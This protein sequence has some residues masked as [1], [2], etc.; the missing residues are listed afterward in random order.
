MVEATPIPTTPKTNK[1]GMTRND[2]IGSASTLCPGCGHD[3][4]TSS[5]ITACFELGVNPTQV[6]KMSG[7]GCSS[8]TPA[9]F[10]KTSHA[11]NSVHGR[12]PSVATGAV[13]ANRSLKTIGISGDG[14]T[15]SIGIGQ[16]IHLLRR[17]IPMVYIIE[18]NGVYG[19]TKGQFSATADLGSKLKS[20][21][22]NEM[23]PVDCCT[24][25]IEMG[26]SF[27][28][29]SFSGDN[30]QLVPLIKAALS[31]RGTALLDV[32]SPCITFNNHEG[33][34]KSYDNVRAHDIP[35]HEIGFV[36]EAA[37]ITAEFEP[38][39]V[40]EI[41]LP[42]GA[43]V[44][45]KKLSREYDPT[46]KFR[47]LTTIEESVVKQELL[48]G[49]I[50]INEESKTFMDMLHLSATPLAHMTEKEL[51]PPKEALAAIMQEAM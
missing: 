51:R 17:N 50:Y 21:V 46:D 11:F 15:A 6:I 45:L 5:I 24:L 4:I 47:A 42:D 29:R 34:T 16:F 49:L 43:K 26:C 14:D 44:R 32:I 8:K 20:G 38:G 39:T 2:Y 13:L 18:N 36:Q 19:L 7:I 10:M 1:L 33:S 35:L 22:V 41:T 9:Y 12:M 40:K 25:A 3:S 28:A 48:T 23:A 30:K 37:P 27:V 31:H